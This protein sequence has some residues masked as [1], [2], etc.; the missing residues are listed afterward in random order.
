MNN[1]E[2]IK[3]RSDIYRDTTSQAIISLDTSAY[4]Q[5]KK[6]LRK[7]EEE[8]VELNNLKDEVEKLKSL[9]SQLLKKDNE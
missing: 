7:R 6:I 5:R 8:E 3:D 4:T 9:V 1:K 2:F